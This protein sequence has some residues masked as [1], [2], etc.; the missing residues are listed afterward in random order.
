[1]S[2]DAFRNTL[3]KRLNE[4]IEAERTAIDLGMLEFPDYKRRA[5]ILQGL[6]QADALIDQTYTDYQKS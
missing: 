3:K 1:M 6:R 2:A 5:G 4:Q